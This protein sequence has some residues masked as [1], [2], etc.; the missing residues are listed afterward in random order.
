MGAAP[1]L[2]PAPTHRLLLQAALLERESA[3][4]AWRRWRS[5]VDLDQLDAGSLRLVPLAFWNL[6]EAIENDAFDR[7][8]RGIVRASWLRGQSLLAEARPALEGLRGAD[9]PVLVIKGAVASRWYPRGFSSRPMLDVDLV[10]PADRRLEAWEL[11]A[12][13]GFVP[14][15]NRSA[16]DFEVLERTS[17]NFRGPRGGELDLHWRALA[18]IPRE[19]ADRIVWAAAGTDSLVELEVRSPAPRHQIFQTLLHAAEWDPDSSIVWVSD[20]VE[21]MRAAA[22]G[23]IDW[24]ALVEEARRLRIEQIVATGLRLVVQEFGAPVADGVLPALARA[25]RWQRRELRALM[26]PP[27]ERSSGERRT[28]A[29]GRSVRSSV[30]PGRR[31]DWRARIDLATSVRRR[32][33]SQWLLPLWAGFVLLERPPW[34]RRMAEALRRRETLPVGAT[35]PFRLEFGRG[36]SAEPFLDEGWEGGIEHG[37]W[38]RGAE[39]S[40]DLRFPASWQPEDL[41]LEIRMLVG[42]FP[43][44]PERRVDL[45]V[46]GRRLARWRQAGTRHAE[47]LPRVSIPRR[48]VRDRRLRI[49]FH[50]LDPYYPTG[51]FGHVSV[52]R[53]FGVHVGS[54]QVEPASRRERFGRADC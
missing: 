3:L 9:I 46:N 48:L 20:L 4:E 53:A 19:E 38:S 47:M 29:L 2:R 10:V 26:R 43:E 50:T 5:R 36:R 21:L 32:L 25:P 12:S 37:R 8:V 31:V 52:L 39:A 54:I 23:E 13:S 14:F 18:G 6:G 1:S 16:T 33:R 34:L 44:S 24:P 35:P 40:L 51:Q 42:L 45:W 11:L 17:W 49:L 30:P 22:P 15:A 7:W 28:V 41:E 27:V